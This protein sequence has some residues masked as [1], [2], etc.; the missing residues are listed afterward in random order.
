MVAVEW[1]KID[2]DRL[3]RLYEGRIDKASRLFPASFTKIEIQRA[4][5]R[6]IT[7]LGNIH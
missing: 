2:L 4:I 5:F 1:G 7:I 3:K 6:I